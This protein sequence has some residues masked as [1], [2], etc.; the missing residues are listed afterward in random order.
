MGGNLG[1]LLLHSVIKEESGVGWFVVD[2]VLPGDG[3]AVLR[4]L[5]QVCKS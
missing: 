5:E 3:K 4:I 2:D 1:G